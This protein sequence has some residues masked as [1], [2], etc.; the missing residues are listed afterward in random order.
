MTVAFGCLHT[1]AMKLLRTL[2]WILL[3]PVLAGAAATGWL[4]THEEEIEALVLEAIGSGLQTDAH[5]TDLQLTWWSSFP[6]IS[7][8]LREVWLKGSTGA[9]DDMLLRAEALHLELDVTQFLRDDFQ[10]ESIRVSNADIALKTSE[11]GAWNVAVWSTGQP[12]K[13]SDRSFSF[14]LNAC[15]FNDVRLTLDNGTT[16]ALLLDD[17]RCGFALD[18]AGAWAVD[19]A[20][21]QLRAE[22]VKIS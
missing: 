17:M 10:V 11:N 3:L 8:T 16:T 20:G 5:I 6:K 7:V 12:A 22:A 1:P 21:E 9:P 19:V 18:D 15:T 14:A 4:L 13:P 2:G